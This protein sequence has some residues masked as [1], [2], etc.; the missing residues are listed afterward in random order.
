MR[1][2]APH[3]TVVLDPAAYAG[4]TLVESDG[5][6]MDTIWHRDCMTLLIAAVTHH[7]RDR[8]DYFVGGNNFLYFNPDQARNRDYR[9]PDFFYVKDGVDRSRPRQYW[10]VWEENGRLPDVVIELLSPT[11]EEEDRTTKFTIYEQVLRIPEYFLYNPA[12]Q[13]L[14]GYR[15]SRRRYRPLVASERGWVW[16]RE[17]GLWLG[18][19]Q[20]EY[21]RTPGVYLRPYTEAGE[22]VLTGEEDKDQR[23]EAATRQATEAARQATES[24]RQA[25]AEKKRADDLAKEVALLR[26]AEPAGTAAR[27]RQWCQGVSGNSAVKP[28]RGP[29]M[30]TTAPHYTVVLDPAA[31]AGITLVESD[32]VPMDTIWHRDCMTLLIAAV[33]HHCRDR[34]DYFVGGNNFLYFNP[35]QAR[36]RDYRGPDFFYVKDGVDRSRPRQ[37]WAVWQESGRLPDVVIELLS[38]TTEEEDRTTKFTIYEQ[39]LRIP[40]YFLYNPA[41]QTVEGYRLSRRRYRPLVANERGWLWSRELGLWLGNWQGEF[42]RTPG[43]YL[44]PYTEAGELVLTGEEDKDQR[45]EAATRQATEA[46]RREAEATRQATEATRQATDATREA[47]EAKRQAAAEKKRADDVAAELARLRASLDQHGQK[48]DTSNGAKP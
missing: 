41:T 33:T 8:H 44:R 35:D 24:A 19:W 28:Y 5:V 38:P 13:T 18:N 15:L 46:A 25:A 27:R 6:P 7:C 36:N 40:E 2:T 43:T 4:I 37:Y 3:Y 17:L 11:T 12:T 22:L 21:F 23:L 20:G 10:A 31:Y 47:A 16:S 1:T 30:S 26:T 14:E 48:P 32:G 29:S 34:N 42:F 9:G 45:L 39:V